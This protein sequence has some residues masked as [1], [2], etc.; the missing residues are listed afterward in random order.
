MLFAGGS[1]FVSLDFC[2]SRALIIQQLLLIFKTFASVAAAFMYPTTSRHI[3]VVCL[4]STT[5][6]SL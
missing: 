2:G 5:S 4:P 1:F 3:Q 6:S